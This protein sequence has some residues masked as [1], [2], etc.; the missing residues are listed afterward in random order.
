MLYKYYMLHL[1]K[2]K[3]FSL[4]PDFFM[5]ENTFSVCMTLGDDIS[6]LPSA[7]SVNWI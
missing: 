1:K 7:Q 2:K 3:D 5:D 4:S 6:A